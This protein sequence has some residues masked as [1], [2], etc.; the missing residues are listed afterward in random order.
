MPITHTRRTGS[1]QRVRETLR[2]TPNIQEAR[3]LNCASMAQWVIRQRTAA[4]AMSPRD[5]EAS[6][7][8]WHDYL[9]NKMSVLPST[10]EGLAGLTVEDLAEAQRNLIARPL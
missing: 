1:G 4:K 9:G 8:H 10:K 6:L 2:S 7:W 5:A 3:C